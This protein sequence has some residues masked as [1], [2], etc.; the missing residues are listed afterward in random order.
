MCIFYPFVAENERGKFMEGLGLARGSTHVVDRKSI[1]DDVLSLY[2][3]ERE[4]LLRE[5]PLQGRIS[6]RFGRR[7]RRTVF[8]VFFQ[9]L[10]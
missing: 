4:N 9:G 1:Y 2:V 3:R 10:L 6:R 8:S 5:Y 7:Y